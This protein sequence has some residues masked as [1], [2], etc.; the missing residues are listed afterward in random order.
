MAEE[1]YHI[2]VDSVANNVWHV[3]PEV[4]GIGRGLAEEV[5]DV[6]AEYLTH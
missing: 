3:I 4:K 5:D 1:R 6:V 2:S